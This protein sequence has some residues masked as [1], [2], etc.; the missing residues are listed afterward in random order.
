MPMISAQC[1]CGNSLS[2]PGTLAGKQITCPACN[3][4]LQVAATW[5]AAPAAV[6]PAGPAAT[7]AAAT[8]PVEADDEFGPLLDELE[9]LASRGPAVAPQPAGPTPRPACQAPAAPQ[10]PAAPAFRP[11]PPAPSAQPPAPACP[12]PPPPTA[13][14]P[15]PTAMPGGL[16]RRINWCA[17]LLGLTLLLPWGPKIAMTMTTGFRFETEVV[18]AIWSWDIVK[19]APRVGL[20]LLCYVAGAIAIAVLQRYRKGTILSL[21]RLGL[22][23]A[24]LALMVTTAGGGR[25]GGLPRAPGGQSDGWQP[26]VLLLGLCGFLVTSHVTARAALGLTARRVQGVFASLLAFGCLMT[27]HFVFDT[28][29]GPA[30]LQFA[31]IAGTFVMGLGAVAAAHGAFL[32]PTATS[33]MAGV[34][35]VYGGLL[36]M[37]GLLILG[38]PALEEGGLLAMTLA[39]NVIAV[40]LCG[41]YLLLSGLSGVI[42]AGIRCR[43]DGIAFMD[44]A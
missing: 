7:P 4:P 37:L 24:L 28:G 40:V 18:G 30:F 25:R 3:K 41:F 20:F 32:R 39:Y 29:G 15:Q 6:R 44:A 31:V 8:A 1:P 42:V 27:I 9:T 2:V 14:A 11:A 23:V 13:T 16:N 35:I 26:L 43:R 34:P 21:A 5:N 33:P 17:G 22:V 38:M 36:S 10:P 12:A 19:G